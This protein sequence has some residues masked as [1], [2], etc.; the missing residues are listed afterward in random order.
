[1]SEKLK[2]IFGKLIDITHGS[3]CD[4][5][6]SFVSHQEPRLNIIRKENKSSDVTDE[7]NKELTSLLSDIKSHFKK[8]GVPLNI[9]QNDTEK[10]KT[11]TS[12]QN[13]GKAALSDA[14]IALQKMQ[15]LA[16]ELGAELVLTDRPAEMANERW[17]LPEERD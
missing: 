13:P 8:A 11:V 16:Q 4:I 6:I 1:M 7:D 17:R 5:N 3:S 2:G 9:T 15:C 12:G 10:S 14:E